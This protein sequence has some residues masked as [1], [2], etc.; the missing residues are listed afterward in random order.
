MTNFRTINADC[1]PDYFPHCEG[2]EVDDRYQAAE[3]KKERER[4][5]ERARERER[6]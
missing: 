1:C 4:G 3:S 5:Y 6:A 2:L